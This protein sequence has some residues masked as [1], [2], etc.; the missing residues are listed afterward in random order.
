M[1]DTYSFTVEGFPV[2]HFQVHV[3]TGKETISE[4]YAFDIAV[5]SDASDDEEVERLA[6]GQR[7]V[8]AWT[9][10]VRPRA[11]H[12]L[13]AAVEL[14]ELHEAPP[15]A[16]R[17]RMRLVPRMW[18][19]KRKRRTRIF[20]KMG[21]REIVSAVLGEAGI[22]T[23][24]HLL[25]DYPVREYCTQYEE[26]DYRFIA[27]L[28]AESGIYFFFP[29]GPPDDGSAAVGDALV[30]GDSVVLADDPAAYPA[31]GSDDREEGVPGDRAPS[32][33][34]LAMQETTASHKDKITHFAARTTVR[35]ESAMFRDYDPE[36]P[37]TR[38]VSSASS[39]HP[40]PAP[41]A[42][43]IDT[44]VAALTG[45]SASAQG[46]EVY[47]HHGPFLF[48]KWSFAGDQAPLILRQKRR[49][50]ST[51]RGEGGCAELAPGHQFTL[52]NHPAAHLNRIYVVTSVEHR[53]EAK[54]QGGEWRVYRNTFACAPVEVTYVPP[55]PK[56]RSV[57]VALTA[58]V[59]GPPGE[60]IHV[61]AMGQIKVQFH[62]DRDGA[63]DDHSSC[64]IRP[65]QAWGGAG[66]GAQFIPRIGMEVIVVFEGG[67]TD[68]PM[69]LG[70]LYNGTHP[71]P[72]ALPADKT[73]SGWRTQSAPGGAGNNEI[74]FQ[75]AAM[76]E[77]I[78][79][80][81]QRNLDEV[82]EMNHTLLIK[83]D[84]FIRLLGSRVETI[85]KNVE[86]H[87]RGDS[88]SYVGGN[89]MNVVA[90][91]SDAR[92][93]GM[94]A[95]RVQGKEHRS[96]TGT[97]DLEYADDLTTRVTGCV[98]TLVGKHDAKRSWLTHA[99]GEAKI[100]SLDK[101]E[102][103]SEG[104]LL[105]R[106]GES[107]IR[108]TADRIEL[109]S[110][111][112][113][114]KGTGGG[115]A[116]SDE[117]IALS[118][119]GDAQLLVKQKIVLK[120]EGASISMDKELKLDGTKI[121]LNSPEQATDTPPEEPAP[122][123]TVVLKDEKGNSLAYQRFL[124]KLDDDT[125]ISGLTDEEGQAELELK[126]AGD[127]SFPDATE[128]DADMSGSLRPYVVRQGDYLD[129]LA[130]VLGFDPDAVWSHDKNAD[131]SAQR[132]KNVLFPGDLLWVPI[133]KKKWD[134]VEKGTTNTY[135]VAVPSTT[136]RL[137]FKDERGPLALEPYVVHG[138]GAPREGTTDESG[139]IEIEMPVHFRECE[140]LFP[141]QNILHPVRVGEMDPLE[142]S[143]GVRKRL[144]HLGYGGAFDSNE[145][146][147]LSE[148]AREA[149][150]MLAIIAFQSDNNLGLTGVVDD[151]TRAA[152][153]KA[154]T[155]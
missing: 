28:L 121:L 85:E 16:G 128:S 83:N 148:D 119:N 127:I 25:R 101:T 5:T 20:Q 100:S 146:R 49:R 2:D 10:G 69:I 151:A 17:Y 66:W 34:F 93:S 114:M 80:H 98:T 152:L 91:N 141:N 96:V 31:I 155:S 111:A 39:T 43:L 21:V 44:A 150:Y 113:T 81:A 84:E 14:E 75:D 144:Q 140:V 124:I 7:A 11:F 60:E 104:E 55:R 29:Q 142:E 154:H 27:R 9:V 48:P 136:V 12:G 134:A 61:D 105:L 117:G 67:D 139:Q 37:M 86:Q 122:P 109:V 53:G 73:R 54:P 147:D 125:E 145:T 30:P 26:S 62:W 8:L 112:V 41:E 74:S 137:V 46:L 24:W 47:D 132:D 63:Y 3:F 64:W 118:S 94:L 32:L 35:A 51:A 153:E 133:P 70:S 33:F 58:T 87:V 107:W 38:L 99:E 82:V 72:F 106:V 15:R 131:I 149:S 59:T 135:V 130:H 42:S 95:T 23:R 79:V 126:T 90:G 129:R 102:V 110:A 123:T 71:P 40:F 92:I 36:R 68:K 18:L 6:L 52:A 13:I 108:I 19:L 103:S 50:A 115:L 116:I 138:L 97:S 1:T 76:K 143:S 45:K 78:Y 57:Q 65:M 88:T 77:Q 22:A 89:R 120:T 4:P 56:R